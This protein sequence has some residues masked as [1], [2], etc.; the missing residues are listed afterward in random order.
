MF[1]MADLAEA[2]SASQERRDGDY[3]SL[4]SLDFKM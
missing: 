4:E 3:A 2:M 1:R